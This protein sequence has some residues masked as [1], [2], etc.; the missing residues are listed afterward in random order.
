M[1]KELEQEG[2]QMSFLDH[3]DE[4]RRRLI[5]SV[6]AIFIAFIICWLV[7]DK[8]F[9]FLSIPINAQI[10]K[11]RIQAQAVNGSPDLNQLKEDEVAQY[12]FVQESAINGVKIPLGTTIEV[13]RVNTDGKADLV[14]VKPWTVGK[15]VVPA[16]SS[17]ARI[18]SDDGSAVYYDETNGLVINKVGGAFTLYMTIA[19][20]TGIGLAIPFLLYQIWAFISP[21]LYKHEKRYAV[22]V[23]LMS[24]FFFVAGAAF[25]Y[26]VA[27]PRACEYLLGLQQSGKFQT[28]IN[29]EDYFDLI[30]MIMLGLGIVFQIPSLSFLLGRIGLLT[31]GMMLKTWRYAIVVILIIAA[32]LTPTPDVYNLMMFALPMLA[33]YFL[34]IGIVWVFGKPRQTDAE[35]AASS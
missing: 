10:R 35:Y 15:N 1:S 18:Q 2:L 7:S 21:G 8:I 16:G 27:F 26:K 3:L 22:P 6:A 30:I 14:T 29:A 11:M 19:L 17:I 12:T 20:Y 24:A 28:L 9:N 31:P 33:L 5:H 32:V 34:S 4:L 13:K 23:I 25:A